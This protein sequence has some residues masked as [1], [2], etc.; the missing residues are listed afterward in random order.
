MEEVYF[1]N[2]FVIIYFDGDGYPSAWFDT[3]EDLN[4]FIKKEALYDDD[5]I[6]IVEVEI[7]RV[8]K[9]DSF[10]S[11]EEEFNKR[12]EELSK[13]GCLKNV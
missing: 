5:V 7:K 9:A 4:Q 8:I 10:E 12:M 13:N 2:K 6:K 3:E 11:R 1:V